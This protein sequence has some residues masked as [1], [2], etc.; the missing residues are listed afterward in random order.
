MGG[1]S[2]IP[3][4]TSSLDGREQVSGASAANRTAI[5]RRLAPLLLLVLLLASGMTASAQVVDSEDGFAARI[6]QERAAAGLAG[7]SPAADLRDVARRHAQRMLERGT[8]FHN[9]NLGSE[10][11]G[12]S[13]VAENVGYGPDVDSIHRMFMQSREHRDII[14]MAE[15]TEIGVGVVRSD[16]GQLW[17]VEVFRRPEAAPAP[18]PPP[19][20]PSNASPA[21]PVT[22]PP[23]VAPAPPTTEAPA[24]TT[25]VPAPVPSTTVAPAPEEALQAAPTAVL[26]RVTVRSAPA[27][28][29]PE[30]AAVTRSVSGPARVAALLLALVVG[31]Q[32]LAVRRLRIVAP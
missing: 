12:W 27:R 19:P 20:P 14:L 17:V 18:A 31:M 3:V 5:V 21:A 10:V 23:T 16:D 25:T 2:V 13:I 28:A 24:P 22:S 9:P 15:V 8:P 7:L 4:Q 30:L 29:V 11:T 32:A 1:D 26:G 6:A